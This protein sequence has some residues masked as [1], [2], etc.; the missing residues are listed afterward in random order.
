MFKK[1]IIG[2]SLAC[3]VALPSAAQTPPEVLKPYKAFTAAQKAGDRDAMVKHAKKAWDQAEKLLGDSKTTGDLA[4]NYAGVLPAD[5]REAAIKAFERAVELAPETTK[6]EAEDKLERYVAMTQLIVTTEKF[7]R[8]KPFISDAQKLIEAKGLQGSTFDGEITALSGLLDYAAGRDRGAAQKYDEALEIFQ[9]EGHEYQS[10]FPYATRIY[11][12]NLLRHDNPI[13]AALEYQVVMQNLEDVVTKDHPI[14]KTAFGKWLIMMSHINEDGKLAEAEQ[15]GVC[16]CWPYDEMR[17]DAPIPAVRFPP[18]MPRSAKRSGHANVR[19]DV[20]DSGKVTNATII[21]S[22]EAVFE[23]NSLKCVESWDFE[24][25]QT[26]DDPET[27]K[28]LVTKISYR[29]TDEK[30]RIIPELGEER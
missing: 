29:L 15:A 30:G 6:A 27:R 21:N 23:R 12:G 20:D 9:G 14:V 16:K 3:L 22:T 28:G 7:K 11:K 26:D 24:P 25:L 19:Y 8:A 1:L 13:D 10:I 18:I 2:A 17:A 5:K 4:Y